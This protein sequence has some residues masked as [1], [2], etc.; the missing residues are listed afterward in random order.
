MSLNAV[1]QRHIGAEGVLGGVIWCCHAIYANVSALCL[2]CYISVRRVDVHV[3][4][5]N[6]LLSS[7]LSHCPY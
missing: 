3:T 4:P 6:Y 5:L 1:A 7:H 2:A